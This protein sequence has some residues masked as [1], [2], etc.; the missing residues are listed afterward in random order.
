MNNDDKLLYDL[1]DKLFL[2]RK[3]YV[4]DLLKKHELNKSLLNSLLAINKKDNLEK[5][6]NTS[7]LSSLSSTFLTKVNSII[8]KIQDVDEKREVEYVVGEVSK[9]ILK[10]LVLN[11]DQPANSTLENLLIALET[12]CE[13]NEWD[14][15]RLKQEINLDLLY[16]VSTKNNHFGSRKQKSAGRKDEYY[17]W[18]G[19]KD[20]LENLITN[21]KDQKIIK[22]IPSMRSW[23]TNEQKCQ[24]VQIDNSRIEFVLIL[25]DELYNRGLITPKGYRAK[26]FTYIESYGVDFDNNVLLKSN[27]K[28]IVYRIKQNEQKY[29]QL[30]LQVSKW[31][32][33]IKPSK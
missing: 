5:L 6:K 25:F 4:L 14:F 8:E 30:R 24:Q 9:G 32:D 12:T 17:Q 18:N 27:Q 13:L 29:T 10:E 11:T 2:D 31:L 26:K 22:S 19:D 7:Y 3:Q 21:L 1:I 23:F 16:V 28:H 33:Y 15:E 20:D